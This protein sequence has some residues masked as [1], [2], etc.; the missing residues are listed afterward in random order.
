MREFYGEAPVL[1]IYICNTFVD[2]DMGCKMKIEPISFLKKKD[3]FLDNKSA[4]GIGGMIVFIAMVLVA[5]IAASG[6][7]TK[8]HSVTRRAGSSCHSEATGWPNGNLW[9]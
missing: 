4:I 2:G 7:V 8:R 3:F 1:I 9:W 6:A 5:G